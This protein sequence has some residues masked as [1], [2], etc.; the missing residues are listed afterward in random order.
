VSRDDYETA[1]EYMEV[2]WT[3]ERKTST[4]KRK[5]CFDCFDSQ[6]AMQVAPVEMM[7]VTKLRHERHV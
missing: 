5:G 4:E 7:R 6:T 1:E 2:H 3:S